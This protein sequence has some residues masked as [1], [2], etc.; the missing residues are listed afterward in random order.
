MDPQTRRLDRRPRRLDTDAFF[1]ADRASAS[2]TPVDLNE[3]HLKPRDPKVDPTQFAYDVAVMAFKRD[4]TASTPVRLQMFA[5]K[6]VTRVTG[7]LNP[8]PHARRLDPPDPAHPERP[9]GIDTSISALRDNATYTSF[10]SSAARA[11]TPTSTERLKVRL[12][13]GTGSES[14]RHGLCGAVEGATEPVL[15]II[16]SGI[17]PTHRPTFVDP[18]RPTDRTAMQTL[19]A[20]NRWGVGITTNMI[21][22]II[23]SHFGRLLNYDITVL[24]AFSTGYL[25]LQE[26]ITGR[27][28]PL[29]KLERV[30]IY[31]CLYGTLKPALQRVKAIKGSA[32]IVAYVVTSGGNSFTVPAGTSPSAAT[33]D[34]LELGGLAIINYINLMGNT[35]FHSITSARLVSEATDTAAPILTSLPAAYDA[36]LKAFVARLPAR[37]SVVSDGTVFRKVRGALPSGAAT[38]NTFGADRANTTPMQ[39]FAQEVGLTRRCIGRAQLLGWPAPPGEEWHDMLL[40]EFAWEYFG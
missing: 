30:V 40:I 6:H 14:F 13:F 9:G 10:P 12:M 34:M 28:F 38:L 36:A 22:T 21:E 29:D 37:N 25:G 31:D 5:N 24:G 17:E 35:L 16:I 26:S 15:L 20:N 33:F 32:H 3:I 7:A 2:T 18:A 23:T 4:D 19:K 11:L 27:L 39:A 8:L 1:A